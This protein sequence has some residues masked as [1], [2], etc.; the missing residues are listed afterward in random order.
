LKVAW[1]IRDLRSLGRSR[2]L[3]G[4]RLRG[5]S[6]V[7]AIVADAAAME[8]GSGLFSLRSAGVAA[9]SLTRG[10]EFT[11]ELASETITYDVPLPTAAF[12]VA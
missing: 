8:I 5:K 6:P 4:C 7:G 1:C 3:K 9:A 12:G 11:P 10:Q 2:Y